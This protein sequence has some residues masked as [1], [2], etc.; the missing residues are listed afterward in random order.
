M[1]IKLFLNKD[2]NENAN[3]FF[4]KAKKLKAKLTGLDK[5]ILMTKNELE[6][7][8]KKKIDFLEKRKVEE[9]IKVHRKPIW[10]E[11]FRHTFTSN[12][13]L[14]VCGKDAGSNEILIKKHMEEGDIVLHTEAAGSPF[15]LMKNARDKADKR[16]IEEAGEFL[17]CFSKQWSTGYGTA[18]AFWVFPEQISKTPQS[19]E[20]ISRGSFMVRGKKNEIKNV[21]LRICFG[22]AIEKVE[23]DDGILDIEIPFSGSEESCLKRCRD[24]FVKIE[25]GQNNYKSLTKELKKRLKVSVIDDLPKYVP[26]N[27]KILKK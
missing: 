20:Y 24:R 4:S 21:R 25:P 15:C 18:D 9:K 27:A 22:I 17:S 7:F 13:F 8:E 10:Y 3:I 23:T 12:E 14:C 1:K 26:N 5:A 2:I 19:G 6:N 11:K 16:D